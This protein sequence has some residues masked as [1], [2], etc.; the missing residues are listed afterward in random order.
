METEYLDFIK[1]FYQLSWNNLTLGITIIISVGGGLITLLGVILPLYWTRSNIKTNK[2]DLAAYKEKMHEEFTQRKK[3]MDADVQSKVSE[4]DNKMKALDE[5]SG[6]IENEMHLLSGNQNA[7]LSM[8]QSDLS[9]KLSCLLCALK[10]YIL[11]KNQSSITITVTSICSAVKDDKALDD[12]DLIMRQCLINYFEED[13]RLL[14]Q[15]D[16]NNSFPIQ[17]LEVIKNKLN[18]NNNGERS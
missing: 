8:S 16:D 5:R 14:R 18:R 1:E 2:E 9:M 3:D 10:E 4:I 12:I 7:F 13:I 11:A 15:F 6:H 17:M